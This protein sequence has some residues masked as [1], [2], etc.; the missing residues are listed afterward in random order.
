MVNNHGSYSFFCL[1]PATNPAKVKF[2]KQAA[3]VFKTDPEGKL[4]IREETEG[5]G[6]RSGGDG[7]REVVDDEEMNIDEVIL[8]RPY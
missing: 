1:C 4:I 3:R 5:E 7:G 8:P 2:S 6:E